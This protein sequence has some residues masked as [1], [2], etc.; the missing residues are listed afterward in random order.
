MQCASAVHYCFS[1]YKPRH[2]ACAIKVGVQVSLVNRTIGV[3]I[4]WVLLEVSKSKSKTPH[5]TLYSWRL[6]EVSK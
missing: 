1:F 3:A 5:M 6:Q 2:L 4:T